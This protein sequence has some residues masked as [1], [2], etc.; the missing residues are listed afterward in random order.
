MHSM[1]F[2]LTT[3]L[4]MVLGYL[5]T[6]ASAQT[7]NGN[8]TGTNNGF[9]YSLYSSGGSATMTLGS[10]G[11]YAINWSGVSDVVGGKGFNPGSA[12]AIGYNVASA[13]GYNNIS[14]YGWLTNPLVEYYIT[15]FGQ[16]YTADATEKGTVTS[17]GHT[18]TTYEHQQVNQPSIQG[19][20]TFEQYLD[21]W[22]GATMGQN[23]VVTTA[24]HFNH[25]SSLG[26]TVGSFNYQILGTE[27]Y[28]GGSG[29]VN[30]TVCAGSCGGGGGGGGGGSTT[31]APYGGTAAAIPGTV[32]AENYDTGGQ[33]V[34]YNVTSTNGTDNG[35]RSDG[36][37]LETAS[38][39]ATGNDLGW[40]AS[41][42]WFK[43][44]VNVATAGTYNVTFL[45]A[46]NSGASDAFHLSN[47]SG[48]NLTGSVAVP[49]TGG[50]QTW[51]TVTT[52]VTLPA[53][54]QTLTL[55]EDNSGW[56]LDSMV[57]ASSGSASC[58][59]DPSAP[60]G[61]TATSESSSAINLGWSAVTSPS[62]CTV[63]A[64]H[65]FRSTASGFTPS[66]SNQIAS[67]SSGT[68]Y[69]DTGLSASTTYYYVV[70]AVDAAGSS[71][72][73]SQASAETGSTTG[74]G[75]FTLSASANSVPVTQGASATDTITVGDLNGFSGSVSLSASGLPSGV[76]ATFG[77]N[78]TTGSSVVTF[79]ASSS[80][81]AGTSIVTI[82]GT[83]GSLTSG[84]SVTL[85]VNP[86]TGGSYCQVVYTISSQWQSGF[87][88]AIT[89]ENTGTTNWNNWTLTWTFANGQTISSLWNGT[90]TQS[91]ANVT[92]SNLSYNG[93]IP[94]GT[95]Y[96][97]M[98]FN[99]TWNNSTNAVPTN[100]AV[101]GTPCG[102]GGSGGGGSGSF[103]LASS[104]S[105]LSVAQGASGT[106]TVTVGDVNGFAGSVSFAAS[107]M[108]S[109]VT[110][111]FSPTSS[112]SS[113]VVTLSAGSSVAAGNYPI[114]IT[115]T[116]GSLTASTSITLTVTTTSGGQSSCSA[117]D[118]MALDG[119]VY[120][121]QMNEYDSTLEECATVSGTGFTITT[122]NFNNTTS[123]S[124]ATYTSIYSGCHWGICTSSNPFPIEENNIASATSS[125]SITQPSGYTNDA[126]Y[127]IW[128]NQTSTTSGQ[129]NGTEIM[130]WLNQQGASPALRYQCW[131]M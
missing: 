44:T 83:S 129:P 92:V 127:D 20:T 102:G 28:S 64:Y 121:F 117:T 36:I 35:Y 82:M 62:N 54:K 53:G 48:T 69:S 42:Q 95:S 130:I 38:S 70:E 16:L 119:G 75:S 39:P 56:N 4:A 58:T 77:T 109:G 45:V 26:M 51:T 97:G 46:G 68:T 65:I 6:G 37:D 89:I 101:N 103:T 110:A 34:A 87:G 126:S 1:K 81:A 9:Y 112:A 93:S 5:P 49:N 63:S 29:S 43:Y 23:A 22:G 114:T 59:T 76:T 41:G 90:E 55:N 105:T 19:T 13:S 128:F 78:P 84:A 106:D 91:G 17:D 74:G 3:L 72:A 15:E 30:A 8:G 50:W 108:P 61:L 122:A 111:S 25:W 104:A 96:T 86:S 85:T 33:G 11:N 116:S 100:F 73:S 12:Q 113:S 94:A 71:S 115:G 47:S 18:Y 79:S 57:F 125:V 118:V 2:V 66:S 24:N 123:G 7:V 60:T 27:S 98:G 32:M 124:P 21:N 14:I 10:A 88:A 52:S 80:A 31:E 131:A 40:T 99:G 120:E 67:V 107:G